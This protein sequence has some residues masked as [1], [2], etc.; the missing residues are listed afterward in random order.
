M[1][2]GKERVIARIS[3]KGSV[4]AV[5]VLPKRPTRESDMPSFGTF[6]PLCE[7]KIRPIL[8][9]NHR[10]PTS[11]LKPMDTLSMNLLKTNVAFKLDALFTLVRAIFSEAETLPFHAASSGLFMGERK[12]GQ[13]FGSA[14][15]FPIIKVWM[16]WLYAHPGSRVTN[17]QLLEKFPLSVLVNAFAVGEI[18]PFVQEVAS[19]RYMAIEADK[20]II[21]LQLFEAKNGPALH[22]FRVKWKSF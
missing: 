16:D 14:S 6:H 12:I 15:D 4:P 9:P 10:N 18:A 17:S 19:S 3:A 5:S 1:A 13:V 21:K 2:P 8:G 20:F 7:G 11:E 22:S